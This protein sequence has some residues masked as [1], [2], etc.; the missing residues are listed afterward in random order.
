M[1]PRWA[2]TAMLLATTASWAQPRAPAAPRGGPLQRAAAQGVTGLSRARLD[3]IGDME[4]LDLRDAPEPEGAL[5]TTPLG[6]T[7]SPWSD[8]ALDGAVHPVDLRAGPLTPLQVVLTSDG[9]RAVALVVMGRPGGGRRGMLYPESRWVQWDGANIALFTGPGILPDAALTLRGRE[10]GVFSYLARDGQPAHLRGETL[11]LADRVVGFTRIVAGQIVG[12]P[13]PLPGSAG[14]DIDTGAVRWDRGIALVLGRENPVPGNATR[15]EMLF[16]VSPHGSALGSPRPLSLEVSS[17]G[18]GARY[19]DLSAS[20]SGDLV[21]AWVVRDGPRAG[22]WVA[23]GITPDDDDTAR[24]ATAAARRRQR[25]RRPLRL[26]QGGGFWGPQVSDRGVLVRREH[27][28][29]SGN[30]LADLLFAGFARDA[31]T[32]FQ[33]VLGS[34][35]DAV[36]SW[37][38]HGLILA[39][40]RGGGGA[41]APLDP[42]VAYGGG[43]RGA[44]RTFNTRD[45]QTFDAL[46]DAVDIAITPVRDG[47]VIA[48]IDGHAEGEDPTR[49]RL[50]LARIAC[51]A[52]PPRAASAPAAPPTRRAPAPRRRPSTRPSR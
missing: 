16:A 2:A 26:L 22:V 37:D 50:R 48:W 18:A 14:L 49:R 21:S 41:E 27:E 13:R 46:R 45:A 42:V 35:W 15:T 10:I 40:L 38:T 11:A 19:I 28:S 31:R 3:S 1:T 12:G 47:A 32:L 52:A 4:T 9:R 33:R 5:E 8:C 20:R 6:P 44:L 34:F 23:R 7:E 17:A 36:P 30:G 24:P 43:D 29:S 25:H 39:G 51:R